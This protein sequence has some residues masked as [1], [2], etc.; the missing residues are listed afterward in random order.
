MK[1]GK[2][3]KMKI[4]LK[5]FPEKVKPI[6]DSDVYSVHDLPFLENLMVSMT[7]LH[8]GKETGGHSHKEEEEVY[9]FLEGEGEMRLGE[10]RFSVGE[11]DVVLIPENHFHKVFNTGGVDLKFLCVFEKYEGRR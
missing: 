1:T 6:R 10:E 3:F 2:E 8:P 7:I 4:S 11:G 5:E 9:I